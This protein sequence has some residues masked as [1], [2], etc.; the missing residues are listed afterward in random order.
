MLDANNLTVEGEKFT[1]EL[2]RLLGKELSAEEWN[3]LYVLG[4][5]TVRTELYGLGAILRHGS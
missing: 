5:G 3:R 1:Q 2:T 4:L